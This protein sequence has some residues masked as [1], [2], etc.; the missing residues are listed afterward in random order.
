MKK[1][2]SVILLIAAIL[3]LSVFADEAKPVTVTLNGETVDCA[4]YGQEATIVEGRTMVPLRAVFEALGASVEWDANTKT[5]VSKRGNIMIDL[6]IG[7]ASLHKY[8][9]DDDGYIIDVAIVPLDVPAQIMN[10]RTLVPVRAVSESFGVYVEWDGDTR[11]VI[12]QS[13]KDSFGF[14][15]MLAEVE[16]FEPKDDLD[17]EVL[18]TVNGVDITA[19]MVR[20][21]V[22][23]MCASSE[24]MSE[25][26]INASVLDF[27]RTTA[28]YEA[29]C[30]E[31]GLE[32]TKANLNEVKAQSEYFRLMYG[33][34]YKDIFA[35]TPYTPYFYHCYTGVYN[36]A[37]GLFLNHLLSDEELVSSTLKSCAAQ[38]AES[39]EYV[40]AKHILVMFKTEEEKAAALEKANEILALVNANPEKFDEYVEMYGEDPGMKSY[41]GGYVFTYGTMVKPFE[42]AAFELEEGEIS[43]IVETSYGY[44]ILVKLPIEAEGL[45]E[46]DLPVSEMFYADL[47]SYFFNDFAA[48][49]NDY[50]IVYAD[51]Y[52]ER[53]ED[54]KEEYKNMM[55][56]S[57]A[58]E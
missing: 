35:A 14:R 33:D 44:H 18:A 23:N 57:E 54:F 52:E 27:Y 7:E 45:E 1:L 38:L 19:A 43:G 48:E 6:V 3:T 2:L 36:M 5:V 17:K 55:A 41:P 16:K 32:F 11:T 53:V 39:G 34:G 40:R 37:G 49:R 13:E 46:T 9:L 58:A 47:N 22:L 42:D 51:N 56:S 4:S 29:K 8:Q 12:L 15:E 20:C 28:F 10:G 25:E 31:L 30:E 50:E 24:G 21:V 26:E